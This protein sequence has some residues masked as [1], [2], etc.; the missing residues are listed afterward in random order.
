MYIIKWAFIYTATENAN[1]SILWKVTWKYGSEAMIISI[2]SSEW[3]PS[4]LHVLKDYSNGYSPTLNIKITFNHYKY[5]SMTIEIVV[6]FHFRD[7]KLRPWGK[8]KITQNHEGGKQGTC[9]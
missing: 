3:S 9:K 1:L 6:L 2:S 7:K 4:S 8:N 5:H